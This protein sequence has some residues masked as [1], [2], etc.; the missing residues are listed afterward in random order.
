MNEDFFALRSD[1]EL[2][3]RFF[4]ENRKLKTGDRRKNRY[5]RIVILKQQDIPQAMKQRDQCE[6]VADPFHEI[7]PPFRSST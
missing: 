5:C 2:H 7:K 1:G 6:D 3:A 4:P